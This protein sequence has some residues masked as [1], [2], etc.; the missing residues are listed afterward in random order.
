MRFYAGLAALRL[1]AAAQD[2]EALRA[3]TLS[4]D[5]KSPAHCE[6]HLRGLDSEAPF[7]GVARLARRFTAGSPGSYSSASAACSTTPGV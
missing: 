5:W 2:M 3:V 4:G 7:R 1:E 6:V